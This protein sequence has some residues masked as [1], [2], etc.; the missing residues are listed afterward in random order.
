MFLFVPDGS[1]S[2]YSAFRDPATSFPTNTTTGA[3][4]LAQ[5]DDTS[6]LVTLTG[7]KTVSLYGQSYSSFYVGS[8]GYITFGSSDT[9]Y[10][11]SLA[12][13]FGKP[14]ISALFDDL[15]PS[16]TAVKW[17]QTTDRVAVTWLNVKEYG[18]TTFNSFQIEMFFDGRIRITCLGITDTGGIIGLSRGQGVPANFVESD[19]TSY[20]A[21]ATSF[22]VT[23]PS[24]ATETAGTLANQGTVKLSAVSGSNVTV[25]LTS[26]S[27]GDLAVP[28]SI[29][30]PAGQTTGTF[31]PT[32]LDN[33]VL[34]G[35]RNVRVTASAPG[36]SS[37]SG[38]IVIN[39]NEIAALAVSAPA[40][41][42]EGIGTAQGTVSVSAPAAGAIGVAMS[43]SDT[44]AL[45]VAPTV[46]I[47]TGQTSATFPITI[48]DDSKI[49]GTHPATITAHVAN[50]TDGSA[51][52]SILD[53]E[54]KNLT[55]VLPTSSIEGSGTLSGAGTVSISGSLTTNLTVS[56]SSNDT[57]EVTAPS[58]VTIPAGQTSAA[59]NV[60]IVDDSVMDGSQTATVGAGAAGFTSGSASIIVKDNEVHHFAVSDVA[61]PVSAG[62]PFGLAITAIN[63]EGT[64]ITNY[65]KTINLTATGNSGTAA[66]SPASV[67]GFSNGVWTGSVTIN[68]IDSNIRIRAGDGAGA[69]GVGNAFDVQLGPLNHFAWSAIAPSQTLGTPIPVTITAKDAG[70]N[71]VPGFSGTAAIGGRVNLATTST[72]VISEVDTGGSDAIEFINVSGSAQ[73]LSNW[74]VSIYDSTTWPAPTFT[75]TIP[76]GTTCAASQAFLLRENGT[77]PGTFPNLNIGSNI[78]WVNSTSGNPVAVLLRNA[79]GTIVDFFCA[80]DA[81]PASITSPASIPTSQWS[82]SPVAANPDEALTYQ[83]QGITD[84]NTAA[85]WTAA[86]PNLGTQNL[87]MTLPFIGG[88]NTLAVSPA[89]TGA[90]QNG[91]WTGT[92]A[93]SQTVNGMYLRA[94]HASGST[95]DSNLF[96]IARADANGDGLPDAW[97]VANG[98]PPG[99]PGSGPLGDPDFDGVPN[100][101]EYALNLD[102][103][104]PDTNGLPSIG[105]AVNPADG[106]LYLT[107]SYRRLI[108]GGGI[109]YVV[110]TSTDLVSWTPAG[111]NAEEVAPPVSVGD[112]ITELETVRIKPAL[113]TPDLPMKAVRLR[114]TS[115]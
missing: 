68:T 70:N 25:T 61:G 4:T 14:R 89:T 109:S 1:A 71:T 16:A 97:Q 20:V 67:S 88:F 79:S 100:L 3:T 105:K 91:V 53:N 51:T 43:S 30:I 95:G 22:K 78:N 10:T 84:Q 77:T 60:T 31:S 106:K 69:G 83:R 38:L 108:N 94:T 55:V 75:F 90:F 6:I 72:I 52:V 114:V 103:Q 2:Y 101:L 37:G 85:D 56:L 63:V 13:H 49:N 5:G 18:G 17:K 19:F 66:I 8:N 57:T 65:S 110:E 27:P 9:T 87:G 47:P 26:S 36:Y 44:A 58:P 50:W 74:T 11:P 15:Y 46:I 76:S 21:S 45:Q 59:F 39:D 93:V 33:T 112:G 113:D 98:L 102:P 99:Q 82:G 29:T 48:T 28:D 41:V 54:N 92:V 111:N 86:T 32:V 115:Q 64:P 24:S 81:T 104:A 7:G 34:D 40:S 62:T 23:L 80:V 96:S 107:F 42:S 12:A 35:S 73:S